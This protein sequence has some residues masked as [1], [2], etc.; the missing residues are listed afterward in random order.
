LFVSPW[1]LGTTL[2]NKFTVVIAGLDPAI[3]LFGKQWITGSRR[4]A[5]AR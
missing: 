3:D 2:A 1:I 5:P 4:F